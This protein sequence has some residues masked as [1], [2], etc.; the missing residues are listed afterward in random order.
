MDTW[1]WI[2]L[3]VIVVVVVAVVAFAA[4]R[5]RRSTPL[6]EGFGPEYER[7]VDEAGD[8]RDAERELEERRRRREELD[9]RPLPAE[10]RESYA[11][12]WQQVQ[13]RFVDDPVGAVRTGDALV[14]RV[15][16][17]RGYPMDDFEQRAADV[18]VDHP[19]VVQNYREGHRLVEEHRAGRGGTEDLRQAMVHLRAL[20]VELL[21]DRD[22]NRDEEGEVS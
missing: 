18:S 15:R 11:A 7:V 20:F 8:R 9:I 22:R 5:R 13:E 14:A 12:E 1:L 3:V 2:V 17:D 21:E 4:L 16:G 10:A 19:H 6:R